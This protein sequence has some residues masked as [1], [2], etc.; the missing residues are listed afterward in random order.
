VP[1]EELFITSKLPPTYHSK[2][3]AALDE[4]LKALDVGYLDLYLMFVPLCTLR[5]LGDKTC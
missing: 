3:K 2:A 1:R 5:M 4:T